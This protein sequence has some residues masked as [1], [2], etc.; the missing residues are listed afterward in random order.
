MKTAELKTTS[1]ANHSIRMK[2]QSFFGKE[3]EGN[4]FSA[5]KESA[6][7]FFDNNIIQTKLSIGQPDDKYE[8]EAD[9]M[10]DKVVQRL[11]T[12]NEISNTPIPSAVNVV[13]AKCNACEEEEKLQR[14]EEELLENDQDIDRKLSSDSLPE[15][16]GDDEDI[17]AKSDGIPNADTSSLE[18]RL[19]ASKGKGSP[20]SRELQSSMG[21][22]FGTDFSGVRIHTGSDAVQMSRE[23]NAQAFTYGNDI[24][25][26]QGKYDTNSSSGKHLLAHELTHTIQQ[27]SGLNKSIQRVIIGDTIQMN[28][29]SG[30]PY[31]VELHGPYSDSAIAEELYG[32]PQAPVRHSNENYSIILVDYPRLLDRWKPSF[33]SGGLTTAQEESEEE[34]QEQEIPNTDIEDLISSERIVPP[35]GVDSLMFRNV[36]LTSDTNRCKAQLLHLYHTHGEAY[37]ALYIDSFARVLGSRYDAQSGRRLSD[38]EVNL[39]NQILPLLRSEFE[40]LISLRDR[41]ATVVKNA[42]VVQLNRNITS[43]DEWKTYI[44]SQM[45]AQIYG[46]AYAVTTRDLYGEVERNP[47]NPTA[48]FSNRDLFEIWAITE[49]P[50]LRGVNERVIRQEIGGG[51]QYCHETNLA[52]QR[53]YR[54]QDLGRNRGLNWQAPENIAPDLA[55]FAEQNPSSAPAIQNRSNRNVSAQGV[56]NTFDTSGIDQNRYPGT[57]SVVDA[58][59]RIRTYIQPLGPDGYG[60]LTSEQILSAQTAPE[61][62][63]SVI[64]KIE[65]RQAKYRLLIEKIQDGDIEYTKLG[66]ILNRLFP[67]AIPEVKLMITADRIHETRF[68]ENLSIGLLIASIASLLLSIFPPTAPLGV[69]MGMGLAAYGV[70]EGYNTMMEG[71]N[72]SLG[73]YSGTFTTEQEEAASRLMVMGVVSMVI[74]AFDFGSSAVSIGRIGLA[75]LTR[76]GRTATLV[77]RV[78]GAS[79]NIAFEI[80]GLTSQRARVIIRDLAGDIIADTTLDFIL[81]EAV[82]SLTAPNSNNEEDPLFSEE[83]PDV[84]YISGRADIPLN[85]MS[86]FTFGEEAFIQRTPESDAYEE[87][88]RQAMRRGSFH[89]RFGWPPEGITHVIQG[90]YH[91]RSGWG[92][93]AIGIYHHPN[94]NI[95]IYIVE[96]KGGLDPSLGRTNAGTQVGRGWIMAKIEGILSSLE[97]GSTDA[98]G[99]R[100][101]RQLVRSMGIEHLSEADAKAFIRRKFREI[102]DSHIGVVVRQH[103]DL[104]PRRTRADGSVRGRGM[105]SQV[106]GLSS[107]GTRV[108]VR[109][110]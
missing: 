29:L 45:P 21:N 24:Y 97:E 13:Q 86:E 110:H 65:E 92:F 16:P 85:D 60:V 32:D 15:P 67:L 79:D 18:S 37:T 52:L 88:V 31:R 7:S 95:S 30:I 9:A 84:I 62:V 23:L 40:S 47:I 102:P 20:M 57:H 72:Y 2:Q 61:L 106:G 100:T 44:T 89:E 66:E 25:F 26:N 104:G 103:A 68:Q 27:N 93:D 38:D 28:T 58:I 1:T 78:A 82:N 17:Q 53:T 6:S 98:V 51:C 22:A 33:R 46:Q 12:E 36:P 105:G 10:A 56:S 81:E 75:T 55:R 87:A 107:S 91:G 19:Q 90:K 70:Y 76:A 96:V 80:S 71:Y 8:L 34:I 5:N 39:G 64:Q 54:D 74:S 59:N 48:P 99:R 11:S 41:F 35:S 69:A 77:S 14:K 43:L 63:S 50:H 42:A 94:G 3:G 101:Y 49:S 83:H 4:F 109:R 108:R 73:Q